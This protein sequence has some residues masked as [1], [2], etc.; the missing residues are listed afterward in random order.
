MDH[1]AFEELVNAVVAVFPTQPRMKI[2]ADLEVTGDANATVERILSGEFL[3]GSRLDPD[4]P[5]KRSAGRRAADSDDGGSDDARFPPLPKSPR[6][7]R[8]SAGRARKSYALSS[9]DASDDGG[10]VDPRHLATQNHAPQRRKSPRTR[11]LPPPPAPQSNR[12]T[13][14]APSD[15]NLRHADSASSDLEIMDHTSASQA[16]PKPKAASAPADVYCLDSDSDADLRPAVA[17]TA[18]P[19]LSSLRGASSSSPRRGFDF[20]LDCPLSSDDSP[21]RAK[22]T[23][24][25]KAGESNAAAKPRKKAAPKKAADEYDSE[26]GSGSPVAKE[27]AKRRPKDPEKAAAQEA[28]KAR[29][30]AER[31]RKKAEKEEKQ[32]E[33]KAHKEEQ[34]RLREVNRVMGKKEATK[35]M[36]VDVDVGIVNR[37]GGGALLENLRK[38]DCQVSV[39]PHPVSDTILWRRR[40]RALWNPDDGNWV[41]LGEERII[42]ESFLVK[43]MTGDELAR[44]IGNRTMVSHLAEIRTTFPGRDIAVLVT[45]LRDYLRRKRNNLSASFQDQVRQQAYGSAGPPASRAPRAATVV[46]GGE[47]VQMQDLPDAAEV[48]QELMRLQMMEKVRVIECEDS[49]ETIDFMI[50]LT[51]EIAM[52]PHKALRENLLDFCPDGKLRKTGTDEGD[53]WLWMLRQIHMVEDS[54]ASAIVQQYPTINS[55]YTA[56][57]RCATMAQAEGL[58]QD[59]VV[60]RHGKSGETNRRLGPALS[61]RIH[62][63]LMG[64]DPEESCR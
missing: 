30:A 21:E 50:G 63:V 45:G 29:K 36:I 52:I 56:Y 61:K 16:R 4:R 47:V 14:P 12:L 60:Q 42:P 39:Q 15:P 46:V 2:E 59:I 19:G 18:L 3:A 49:E 54:S 62:T 51:T 28:E 57:K 26:A 20:R 55:L 6:P 25:K 44:R 31:E 53:T 1:D 10:L 34:K 9:S 41:P 5:A 24:K 35:D 37:P 38:Q 58:L 32:R 64:E 40:T 23:R 8:S 43:L 22:P 27:K 13:V 33:E 11:P 7:S 48:S 17:K